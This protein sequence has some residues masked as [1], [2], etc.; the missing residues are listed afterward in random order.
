MVILSW[1][2]FHGYTFMVILS[3]LYFHGYTFMVILSWLYFH[4]YT[5]MVILS[6]LY[7]H[8]YTFMVILSGL[9]LLRCRNSHDLR[10]QVIIYFFH[11]TSH[12]R[13]PIDIYAHSVS[14]CFN[15]LNA[16]TNLKFTNLERSGQ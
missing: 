3:W 2:Y 14:V 11:P 1:L 12:I 6:W 15:S 7:F 9:M 4:G 16:V 5:F 10:N 8:G 13:N